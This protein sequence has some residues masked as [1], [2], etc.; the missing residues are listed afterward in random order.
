MS[1]CRASKRV[2][3]FFRKREVR[4]RLGRVSDP[5]QA[6]GRRWALPQV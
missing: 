6:R 2:S 4:Q 1:D 5:R 3:R